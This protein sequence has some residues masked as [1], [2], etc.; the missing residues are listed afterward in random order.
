MAPY[1]KENNTISVLANTVWRC[2]GNE[3][4][5]LACLWSPIHVQRLCQSCG[6]GFWPVAA[7]TRIKRA[8]IVLDLVD[9]GGE[10][11]VLGDIG[12][13]L[14]RV[15]SVGY[16]TNA[17]ILL[18]L[19]LAGL[20][21]MLADGLDILRGR[22]DVAALATCAVLD[23][24]K[25]AEENMFGEAR[26]NGASARDRSGDKRQGYATSSRATYSILRPSCAPLTVCGT[27]GCC[28]K[29][30]APASKSMSSSIV[31]G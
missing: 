23:E 21:D 8:E 29:L 7:T 27:C 2:I 6:D 14:W 13:V 3:N 10:P 5:H 15:I 9:I 22:G 20:E 19:Q 16:E 24:D 28:W 1:R 17:E 18:S 25:I 4:N 11:K 12:V 31:L 26:M 30:D